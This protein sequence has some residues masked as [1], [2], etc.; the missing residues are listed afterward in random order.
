MDEK[1]SITI[2]TMIYNE[3]YVTLVPTRMLKYL[4]GLYVDGT[5]SMKVPNGLVKVV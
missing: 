5:V 4:R 2:I 1:V 3:I